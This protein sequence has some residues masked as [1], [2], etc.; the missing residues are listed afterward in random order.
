VTV[1]AA[2]ILCACGSKEPA[3][4]KVSLTGDDEV[5]A[6]VNGTP[7]SKYDVEL[8]IRSNFG[9]TTAAKLGADGREK[10]LKSLVQSR[11]IAQAQEKELTDKDRAVLAKKVAAYREEQ[12]VKQYLA[13]HTPPEPV[14]GAM[15]E[16]YYS[17]NPE[18]FGAETTRFYEMV[19]S[20]RSLA[21]AERDPL[22]EAMG[23]PGEQHDWSAW[24]SGLAG[25]GHPIQYRKGQVDEKL[26]HPRLVKMMRTLKKG[27]A[28]RVSFIEGKAYAVRI[29]A[30]NRTPPKP[31]EEVR[32][33]IAKSLRPVQLKNAVKKASEQVLEE[34]KVS[35]R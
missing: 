24:A 14:S 5:L 22:L 26:L 27:Q 21:A 7:I 28:S 13:K 32:A 1:V 4:P 20:T 6:E 18:K 16:E 15:I 29:S 9:A 2:A 23:K 8:S 33:Q 10:V 30:E 35:Y 17:E 31:L 19:A 12:L 25:K 34:A 3:K 11:A